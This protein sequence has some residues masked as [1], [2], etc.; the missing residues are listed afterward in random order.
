MCAQRVLTNMVPVLLHLSH[1]VTL[2]VA[3][4]HFTATEISF[5]LL[6][7]GDET[8][9]RLGAIDVVDTLIS[10]PQCSFGPFA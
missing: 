5:S 9:S 10:S 2:N 6:C 4:A 3:S 8:A 7:N 1:P